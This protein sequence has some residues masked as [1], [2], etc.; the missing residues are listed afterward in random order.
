M[1]VNI[2][3]VYSYGV[4][5]SRHNKNKYGQILCE[6]DVCDKPTLFIVIMFYY[7]LISCSIL[8]TNKIGQYHRK[9]KK[10]DRWTAIL[11]FSFLCDV[12]FL[13][14]IIFTPLLQVNARRR[15]WNYTQTH[16]WIWKWSDSELA[17]QFL[18]ICV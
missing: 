7:V 17:L 11:Y 10:N 9:K 4:N 15:A 14:Q 6:R 1:M 8:Y 16:D 3:S 12:V 18:C 2:C 5:V 13:V